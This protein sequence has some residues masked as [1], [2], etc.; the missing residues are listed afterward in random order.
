M[1]NL[2]DALVTIHGFGSGYLN[3][4]FSIPNWNNRVNSIGDAL[5][6]YVRDA[7]CNSFHIVNGVQKRSAYNR[8]FSYLGNSNNPPDLMLRSGDA[9]E[10]KKKENTT[11]DIPLNSSYPKDYLY[12]DTP[13][14]SATCR[15]CEVWTK[16]DMLYVVGVCEETRVSKLWLVYGNC[17]M[18]D[19][20]VYER[21][22][23]AI[24]NGIEQIPDVSFS[25]T[26][27]LGR[28]NRVD[29]LG[30]TYLRVRGMWG[31]KSPI[32]IFPDE[33]GQGDLVIRAVMFRSKYNA[34]PAA[35]KERIENMLS[36]NLTIESIQITSPNNGAA[37]LDG[38]Q[39]TI[40]I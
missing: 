28:V 25:P 39:I 11:S 19:R 30:F 5:E 38:I 36:A 31:I 3:S 18:A 17:F 35:S 16:K 29:P 12:M 27:E 22:K 24:R 33:I 1:R 26:S 13:G 40:R 14:I 34:F 6:L 9:I 8:E 23:S 10:V 32:V 15:G 4:Y 2:L 7:F 21:I 37:L 20:A